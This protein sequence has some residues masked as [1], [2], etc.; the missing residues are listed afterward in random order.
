M[1]ASRTLER[2]KVLHRVRGSPGSCTS[3]H[4]SRAEFELI[5]R[6]DWVVQQLSSARATLQ[7]GDSCQFPLLFSPKRGP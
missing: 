5:M 6:F 7:R 1:R 2:G 3:G 4:I